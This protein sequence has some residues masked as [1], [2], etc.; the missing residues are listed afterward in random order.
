MGKELDKSLKQQV[1]L[2]KFRSNY[3]INETPK[4]R[5]LLDSGED[6]DSVPPEAYADRNVTTQD[7]VPSPQ[8]PTYS[9]VYEAGDQ[10]PP[11]TL[12]GRTPHEPES[13]VTQQQPPDV[14]TPEMPEVPGEE[15]PTEIS[16]SGE[17]RDTEVEPELGL[18]EP[19]GVEK[20]ADEIQN[21]IIRHNVEAM[22]K[23]DD[24]LNNLA[25]MTAKLD[26]K[27]VEL[28]KDVEEVKEPTSG[29]KLMKQKE[30]SY[31]YYFNLNDLWSDNW[32]EKQNE[33]GGIRQLPD[34]TY[35]ADFDDIRG[36]SDIDIERSFTDSI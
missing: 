5:P 17:V 34:G 18:E 9:S 25:D 36:K 23:I 10:E 20:S 2:I 11:E 29:E 31:P 8:S 28:N 22:K 15:P 3:R 19:I 1:E 21:E 16:P 7:G 14:D 30:S 26:A 13:N 35:V 24:Q 6:Y 33:S 27:L 4:Y 12:K 32:F